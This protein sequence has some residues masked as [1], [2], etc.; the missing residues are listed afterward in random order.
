[1]L[2]LPANYRKAIRREMNRYDILQSITIDEY[3]ASVMCKKQKDLTITDV[4]EYLSHMVFEA[5][6][7]ELIIQEK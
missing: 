6:V 3:L 7:K 1:M 4:E 5:K 2:K